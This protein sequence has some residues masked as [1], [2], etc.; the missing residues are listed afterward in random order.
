MVSNPSIYSK[1]P[2]SRRRYST[3]HL[4]CTLFSE[5]L[6]I[7][8]N[9]ATEPAL[10][11]PRLPSI[12]ERRCVTVRHPSPVLAAMPP[13]TPTLRSSTALLCS[14][15][16]RTQ[17]FRPL[18]H[19]IVAELLPSSLRYRPQRRARLKQRIEKTSSM[20]KNSNFQHRAGVTKQN[21]YHVTLE[22]HTYLDP[23]HSD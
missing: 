19:G 17:P 4:P 8:K 16:L 18:V 23:K 21:R 12:A 5:Y 2:T 14:K 20:S 15:R 10:L 22:A 9:T 6:S 11:A 3:E 13:A 7:P 1:R